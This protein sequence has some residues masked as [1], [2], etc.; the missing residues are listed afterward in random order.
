MESEASFDL[1][2]LLKMNQN[3]AI[4]CKANVLVF[5]FTLEQRIMKCLFE[6]KKKMAHFLFF[7]LCN[8]IFSSNFNLCDNQASFLTSYPSLPHS[9]SSRNHLHETCT[10]YEVRMTLIPPPTPQLP[11]ILVRSLQS[12]S[13]KYW[14][15]DF[16]F[17]EAFPLIPT[18]MRGNR[19]RL[20]N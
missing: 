11:H 12:L 8:L 13:G 2:L 9:P 17:G 6:K 5:M 4:F 1:L 19:H 7:C 16:S 3:L 20:Q 18:P 10:F 15:S 14:I